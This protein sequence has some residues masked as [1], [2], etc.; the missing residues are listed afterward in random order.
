M[1]QRI[2]EESKLE[3]GEPVDPRLPWVRVVHDLAEARQVERPA[4]RIAALDHSGRAL[5]DAL[6]AGPM[7]RG[8]RTLDV[9][10]LVYPTRFAFNGAVPLPWPY[11]VMKH[12][13]LLVELDTPEGPKKLLFNPTDAD[14]SQAG[15]PF[16]QG[17]T[18]ELGRVAPFA[19]DLI[20][21]RNRPL[22]ERLAE[23]GVRP[24]DID[25]LAFD[26]FHTQD[27]RPLLGTADRPSR[28][29]NALLLAPA[30]E[31]DHWGALHPMQRAWFVAEGR[32]G[33]PL[34]RVVLTDGDLA[35]GDGALLLSTPGHTVGNQTLFVHGAEGVFGFCENGCS[36]DSWS[37]RSST[38]V[39]LRRYAEQYGV[40]VVLNANTPELGGEQYASMMLERAV[41]D[42]VP[43]DPEAVQMFPS[44]EVTWTPL[45][46]GVRPRTLFEHRDSGS[47]TAT[48]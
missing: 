12:R 9:S 15:T 40:D 6:R 10:A 32:D 5:G 41:V 1:N 31:W 38:I 25:L 3:R 17:L 34:D 24:E 21:R 8:V 23:L 2:S 33:V 45:A 19:V 28:F 27:L 46:P 16:F 7:A 36:A 18:R 4:E 26:H 42:A 39:G 13:S 14:A 37:P 44:S 43:N 47:I 35:L 48:P 20:K 11:V 22:V 29:P 30:R